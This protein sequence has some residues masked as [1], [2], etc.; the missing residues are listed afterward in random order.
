M[1][2]TRSW[3]IGLL[4]V[5]AIGAPSWAQSIDTSINVRWQD[6]PNGTIVHQLIDVDWELV[7]SLYPTSAGLAG[8]CADLVQDASNPAKFDIPPADPGSLPSE[9]EGFSWPTG[10]GNPGEGGNPSGYFGLQRGALGEQNLVQI[11]GAQ[12]SFGVSGVT[13]GTDV[14]V[15]ANV[16]Q[17]PIVAMAG[18]F[19]VQREPGRYVFHLENIDATVFEQVN[20]PPAS[21]PARRA[22]V[23]SSAMGMNFVSCIGDIDHDGVVGL[24]DLAAL[25]GSYGAC[26]GD[27]AYDP[28]ADLIVDG[29]VGLADLSELLGNYGTH[30]LE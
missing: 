30:C 2:S 24:S 3:G 7:I 29:C 28:E 8:F 27:P 4:T 11:G 25:M 1:N 23:M 5:L 10:I 21:S 20:P 18:S 9:M 6:M 19:P 16:G 22:S 17:P 14:D 12:N 13:M 15:D 26:E